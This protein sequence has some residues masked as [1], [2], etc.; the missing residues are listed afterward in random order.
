MIR[1]RRKLSQAKAVD[2][3]FQ[4]RYVVAVWN[5]WVNKP[6]LLRMRTLLG[7]NFIDTVRVEEFT[8]NTKI[9]VV[10]IERQM[11]RIEVTRS[12]TA[13]PGDNSSHGAWL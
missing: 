13:N 6:K 5:C 7:E 8:R 9:R 4:M 10:H 3:K 2:E 11:E 12:Q 1:V